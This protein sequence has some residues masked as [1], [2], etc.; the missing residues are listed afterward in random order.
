M[1]CSRFNSEQSGGHGKW[2]QTI[3]LIILAAC[4]AKGTN[5]DPDQNK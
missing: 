1:R 3:A 5:S 2:E 4:R